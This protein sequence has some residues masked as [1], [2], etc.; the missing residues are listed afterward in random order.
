MT[1]PATEFELGQWEKD[2]ARMI[3]CVRCGG[4]GHICT[5]QRRTDP[6]R[7][8]ECDRCEGLG[9]TAADNRLVRLVAEVRELREEI[10]RLKKGNTTP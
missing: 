3:L 9:R 8:Q 6:E 10:E 7:W 1:T 4:G 5:R 2:G